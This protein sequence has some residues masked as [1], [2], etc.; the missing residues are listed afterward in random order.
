MN[1]LFIDIEFRYWFIEFEFAY[2]IWIVQKIRYF[3]IEFKYEIVIYTDHLSIVDIIKQIILISSNSDKFNLRLVRAELYLFQYT[4]DIRYRVGKDNIVPDVF[5]RLIYLKHDSN[6]LFEN[7][8]I[9]EDAINKYYYYNIIVIE[10]SDEFKNN[11][12][13]RYD[14]KDK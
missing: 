3:I 7:E 10:I 5:S 11:I 12:K 1:K 6:S 2:I 14:N 13:K 4:L 8:N 9:F